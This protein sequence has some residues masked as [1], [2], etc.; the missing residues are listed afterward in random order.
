MTA[1]DPRALPPH[2]RPVMAQR[3]R[4]LL[5]AHWEVPAAA[6]SARLPPGLEPDLFHGRAYIGLVPFKMEAIRP[7]RLPPLPWLSWFLEMNLRTYVV[8]RQ[9]RAGVWFFSLE[10][11]RLPA[12]WLARELFQLPYHHA[13]MRVGAIGATFA[14]HCQRDG[15]PAGRCRTLWSVGAA[16]P[17]PEPGSLTHFL[18]ERYL[19]HAW[20]PRAKTLHHA[21]VWHEPYP[22]RAAVLHEAATDIFLWNGLPTPRDPPAHVA[23]SPG[24]LVQVHPLEPS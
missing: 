22:L 13:R 6:V 16:L 15:M 21:R 23:A 7:V 4:D 1:T 12:V 19:L 9:G 17:A 18:I 5:F 11:N 14:H 2:T 8:D 10:A 24:V 3:W 20:D